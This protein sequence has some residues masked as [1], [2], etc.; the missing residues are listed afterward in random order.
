MTRSHANQI[1]IIEASKSNSTYLGDLLNIHNDYFEQMVDKMYPKEL[2]FN[3]TNTTDTEAPFLELYL[4][5]INIICT[6]IDDKRGDI[7]FDAV[8]FPFVIGNV[9][10]ATSVTY[11]F[12]SWFVLLEHLANQSP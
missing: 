3:Q 11:I 6:E 4:S 12:L 5:I 7:D 2:Q 9:R 1:N 10:R 8:N